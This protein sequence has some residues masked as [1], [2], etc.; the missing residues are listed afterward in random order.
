MTE[1]KPSQEKV[2][3]GD[4][5]TV[6]ADRCG[7]A[8]LTTSEGQDLQ[9]EDCYIFLTLTEILSPSDVLHLRDIGLR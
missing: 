9:L 3:I 7:T 1:V 6:T 5:M 2:T 8:C 4:S